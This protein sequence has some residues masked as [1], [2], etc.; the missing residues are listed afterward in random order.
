MEIYAFFAAGAAGVAA[1]VA[2][3]ADHG[4]E[5]RVPTLAVHFLEE[6][7]MSPSQVVPV[8]VLS[9]AYRDT[10]LGE[11]LPSTLV[12]L[13]ALADTVP[14]SAICCKVFNPLLVSDPLKPAG[15]LGI[16]G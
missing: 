16:L 3:G 4:F 14:E 1:G 8:F 11:E 12:Y 9:Y 15:T 13:I 2:A 7:Y 6:Q 5:Q 10:L